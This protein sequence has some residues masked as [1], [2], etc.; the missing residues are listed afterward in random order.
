MCASHDSRLQAEVFQ[1][2]L[3]DASFSNA[4][5]TS[6]SQFL[7][8]QCIT[9][10]MEMDSHVHGAHAWHRTSSQQCALHQLMASS[11]SI[12][13]NTQ[14]ASRQT[15]FRTSNPWQCCTVSMLLPRHSLPSMIF[16]VRE[17]LL[18]C[19]ASLLSLGLEQPWSA[20]LA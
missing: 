20:D 19:H 15:A 16:R 12:H 17:Y 6:P 3:D 7:G 10:L 18:C 13:T 11:L 9:Q 2:F 14:T 4:C 1:T 8:S 5:Y